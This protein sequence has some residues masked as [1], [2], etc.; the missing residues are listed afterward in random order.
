M[1]LQNITGY[2]TRRNL[3]A[4]LL[5]AVIGISSVE[6]LPAQLIDFHTNQAGVP[7]LDDDPLVRTTPFVF[8]P[9]QIF[10]GFDTDGDTFADMDGFF[11]DQGG[12]GGG[13]TGFP[14]G[15]DGP[16]A[17]W[18]GV[19]GPFFMR[20]FSPGNDFGKLVIR[21]VGGT[22]TAA[23]GEIWDIDGTQQ[24]GGPPGFT[25]EYTVTAYDTGGTLLAT[26]VSPL[27]VLDSQFAPLDGKPW[28]FAFSGISAGIARIDID[29]TGTKPMNIGLAFN[30][31]RPTQ[32][33]EPGVLFL[34]G[35]ALVPAAFRRWR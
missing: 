2:V 35:T 34:A 21:Y 33:P 19:L 24:P 18:G 27:G 11:E 28:V 31:F 14:N 20:S 26:Q 7:P 32:A 3:T 13:F 17:G 30:N 9:L 23:S 25:E 15:T 29:F 8:G 22:V 4:S 16:D 6:L 5:G 1:A 12:S 10:M